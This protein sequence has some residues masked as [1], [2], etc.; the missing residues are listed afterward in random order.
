MKKKYMPR[1]CLD[2]IHCRKLGQIDSEVACHFCF[3]TGHMRGETPT[4]AGCSHKVAATAVEKH[5]Y[6]DANSQYY[7]VPFGRKRKRKGA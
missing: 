2:C 7:G 1:G 3:D 5:R 4:A 6:A